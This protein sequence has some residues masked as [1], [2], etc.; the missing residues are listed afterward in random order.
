M[1]PEEHMDDSFS[2]LIQ[3][4]SYEEL[5]KLSNILALQDGMPVKT[6]NDWQK[7]REELYDTVIEKQ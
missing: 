7:N 6:K 4:T 5:G 3:I 1:D 2:N